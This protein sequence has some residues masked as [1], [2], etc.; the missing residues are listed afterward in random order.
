MRS[1]LQYYIRRWASPFTFFCLY[2][3]CSLSIRHAP[4]I[5]IYIYIYVCV[6]VCVCVVI[7]ATTNCLILATWPQLGCFHVVFTFFCTLACQFKRLESQVSLNAERV[8][9]WNLRWNIVECAFTRKLDIISFE[10]GHAFLLHMQ[11]FE[12][13]RIMRGVD[14]GFLRSMN[15]TSHGLLPPWSTWESHDNLISCPPHLHFVK[16]LHYHVRDLINKGWM[17]YKLHHFLPC[18]WT[19]YIVARKLM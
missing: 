16:S 3:A 8:K 18:L 1:G 2:Y 19:G 15:F 14:G 17:A 13:M 10:C 12:I 5:Y 4:W 6:C 11:H 7:R 9:I